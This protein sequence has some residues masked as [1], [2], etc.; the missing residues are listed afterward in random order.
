VASDTQGVE[1][2]WDGENLKCSY[3]KCHNQLAT[4]GQLSYAVSLCNKCIHAACFHHY[5]SKAKFNFEVHTDVFCCA[6]KACCTKFC[7]GNKGSAT[8]W[9]SDGP[10]GS[11]TIPSS[12]TDWWT[13]GDNWSK[14]H[15]GKGVNGKTG[16]TKK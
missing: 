11:N 1:E 10:N 16:E 6:T 13:M 15:G 5:L 12:E 4:K 14:Y 7:V 2:V 9:D 8:C 3:K